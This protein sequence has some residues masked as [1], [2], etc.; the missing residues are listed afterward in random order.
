[1]RRL[2]LVV[3]L[4]ATLALTGCGVA[5]PVTSPG[6]P[7]PTPSESVGQVQPAGHPFDVATGL[8]APWSILRISDETLISQRDDGRILRVASDGS[9]T[10]VGVVPDVAFGGEGGLLGL[11]YLA[12]GDGAWVYAYL[13]S[14]TDNR[15]V[16]MPYDDGEFGETEVV[17]TGL[18][19]AG[20]HNGGRI[21]FGP[22][23]MLYAT[24]GD[25]AAPGL[26]QDPASL[27]GKILRMTPEG[28]VPDDNP[29]P[30]SFVYSLGHR[31]PQGLA[32]DA[33]GQL[34]AAEFGQNTWDEFNRIEPGANYGWPVVEGQTGDPRFVD[35]VLQWATSDASPSGLAYVDG[36]FFLAAL[37]GERV[38][39]IYVA[40]DGTAGA[41]PW[42]VGEFGRI[43][44]VAAGPDGSLWFLTN[45]TDGRGDPRDGDDRLMQVRLVPLVEG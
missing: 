33:D 43:R 36:T 45:N 15:I 39:A 8:T 28:D 41:T 9:T 11:A 17:L 35:P 20:N 40:D 38:W 19:K 16:R 31:N 37:K 18:A 14:A 26:A 12:D 24:V 4:T 34:W 25:A 27:N 42:F 44:D 2:L 23:G 1:M 6:T 10:E 22:D 3:G 30:G 13:T 29:T 7:A 32:W 21:A 5:N